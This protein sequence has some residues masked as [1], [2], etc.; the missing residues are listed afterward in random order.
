M[1][2][3]FIKG[4]QVRA[5]QGDKP[6]IAGV[7]AVYDQAYDTG[8]FSE[9]IASGAFD[10]ALKEKQDVRCLFNHDVN[11]LLGRTKSG[12]LRIENSPDGLRYD[13]DTDADTSVGKDVLRM[14]ERGDIDGC[15]F[16]FT[17]RK[18]T[19]SDEFDENGRY[20]K[21]HRQIDDLDLYDVGP[22]TFPAYTETSVGVRS[23]WP[24]GVPVEKRSHIEALRETGKP[25]RRSAECQC[26]C[27][28][29]ANGNCDDC[30]PGDCGDEVNCRCE[31][32]QIANLTMRARSHAHGA[33]IHLV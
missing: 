19:W 33:G 7:A 32:S 27:D 24:D 5:K 28:P 22:V 17:V 21:S 6:G 25:A 26:D 31:R 10:R 9:T 14:I 3:R 29:C 4:G 20:V 11:Q 30:G 12:T 2:R 18:D 8:W 15:S 16:S 13:C 1:E 23:A